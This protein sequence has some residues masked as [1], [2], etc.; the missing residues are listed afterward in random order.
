MFRIGEFAA[1]TQVPISQLRYYDEIGLFKPAHTS[2]DSGYRYYRAEQIAELD[3]II[4][5]KDLGFSLDQIRGM[6]HEN[7]KPNEISLLLNQRREQII[8]TLKEEVARLRQIETRLEQL[9][10]EGQLSAHRVMVKPVEAVRYLAVQANHDDH[11]EA[12]VMSAVYAARSE[13]RMPKRA[14]L[15]TVMYEADE[16]QAAY[17]VGYIVGQSVKRGVTLESGMA[18]K[19][20]TLPAVEHMATLVYAGHW[21]DNHAAFG[22]LGRWLEQHNYRVAGAFRKV[23]HQLNNPDMDT[24]AVVELQIPVMPE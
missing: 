2:P 11:S 12:D 13:I 3:R 9:E 22:E 14:Q 10:R 19:L 23:F 18:L 7:I 20:Q 6:V 4:V 15:M 5:L 8:Q 1:L 24:R 16:G 17:A 21:N